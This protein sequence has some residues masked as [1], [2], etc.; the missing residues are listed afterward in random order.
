[1]HLV[2]E[3]TDSIQRAE[4]ALESYMQIIK[5]AKDLLAKL[6]DLEQCSAIIYDDQLVFEPYGWESFDKLRK[7]L[8]S[9]YP[10]Y[11]DKMWTADNPSGGKYFL[12]RYHT[13]IPYLEI[14]VNYDNVDDIRIPGSKNCKWKEVVDTRMALVCE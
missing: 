8:R 6:P 2:N 7:E 13:N 9:I 12:V 4:K 11:E 10:N 5:L 1:M 3:L 14:W